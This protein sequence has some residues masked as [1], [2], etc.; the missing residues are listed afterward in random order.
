VKAD[1]LE[2]DTK[3]KTVD[4]FFRAYLLWLFR[5]VLFY[6]SQGDAMARY[7]I[8]RT[9]RLAYA[10][11]DAVPWICWGNFVLAGMYRGLCSGVL[12]G[13][14]VEAIFFGYPLLLQ[15]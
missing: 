1:Y 13:R 14:S 11:L 10:P 4:R 7:L 2:D 9:Q 6:S 12:K 8:P 15:L 5:F 3:P